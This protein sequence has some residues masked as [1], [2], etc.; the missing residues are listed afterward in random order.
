MCDLDCMH[1]LSPILVC[2]AIAQPCFAQSEGRATQIV[3][4]WSD[5]IDAGETENST[6]VAIRAGEIVAQTSIGVSTD[7]PMPLA[8]LSKSVTAAC[9]LNL[10]DSGLVSLEM[11]LDDVLGISGP[12][13][14]VTLN[15]LL[16]H[17]SGIWPDETQG[18][19]TLHGAQT[20]QTRRIAQQAMARDVQEGEVGVF[21]YSNENYAIL[22]AVIEDVTGK[23]YAQA[24]AEAV[25]EPLG[26]QSATIEGEWGAH[27]AWGGWS[28][29][30]QD[31]ARFAWAHFGPTSQAGANPQDWP[32]ADIGN[33]I[34]FGMG[35]LWRKTDTSHLIWSSG[36]LC[37]DNSGDGGYFARYGE[38]WLVVTL[39]GD[40]LAGTDRLADLD[41]SL[42]RAATE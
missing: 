26:I 37:W 2:L 15:Q 31:Y 4:A 40:C 21:A 41:N 5:W 14:A 24:C 9:I 32:T 33:G 11:K 13:A 3:T 34:N 27:G 17:T 7:T 6:V 1:M 38:E 30:A 29:S 23:A 12:V 8:S 18:N 16:T 28:M 39:Y 35:V 22:G 19:A 36:M 20:D 42:F 10:S 25:L